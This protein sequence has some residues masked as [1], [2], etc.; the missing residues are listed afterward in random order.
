MN[1]FLFAI[2][3]LMPLI[4]LALLGYGLRRSGVLSDAFIDVLNR[5]I[6]VVA[7]PVLIFLAMAKIDDVS[8]LSGG[9]LVFALVAVLLTVILGLLSSRLF[10]KED[11]ERP[12]VVQAFFRGNFVLI[13]IPLVTQVG[14]LEALAIMVLLNALLIPVTNTLSIVV[15]SLYQT[16]TR[17]SLETMRHVAL[18]TIK[19]PMMIA[20]FVGLLAF[21]FQPVWVGI[22]DVAPFIPS[23]LEMVGQT[24][25]PMALIAVGGQ[26]RFKESGAYRT[27]MVVSTLGRMVVVPLVI[28]LPAVLWFDTHIPLAAW[29]ALMALFASPVAVSSVA[30]TRGLHGDD[31]LAS[32]LVLSTT[33]FGLFTLFILVALMNYGGLI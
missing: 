18:S 17:L 16:N 2:D 33:A 30:V 26:F 7:L 31:V 13:G 20:I 4:A 8:A 14:G 19:N 29:P 1:S 23:T 9:L 25:T 24:A 28:L 3:A 10:V 21:L 15:F 27:A 32:H 5:Y 6:F 12:V 11:R 22:S